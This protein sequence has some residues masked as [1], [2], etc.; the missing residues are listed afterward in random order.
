MQRIVT[1]TRDV[2]E[3]MRRKINLLR[4][5][6]TRNAMNFS[7]TEVDDL[8]MLCEEVEDFAEDIVCNLSISEEFL[9]E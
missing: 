7:E 8:N 1:E 6:H 9:L 5:L 2:T 4:R 3:I